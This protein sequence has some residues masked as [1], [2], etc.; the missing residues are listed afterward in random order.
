MNKEIK[1]ETFLFIGLKKFTILINQKDTFEI[2]HKNE[3]NFTDEINDFQFEKLANFLD[4][5]IF[6]IE[7]KLD[8]LIQNIY[9]ILEHKD[10]IPIGISTKKQN[11]GNNIKDDYL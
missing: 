8:F 2:I 9:I 4:E 6:N 10:F 3:I 5:N 7:K 11:L 1:Y